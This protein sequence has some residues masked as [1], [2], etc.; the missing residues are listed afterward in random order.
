[1][2]SSGK[3]N[4]PQQAKES[5][6]KSKSRPNS[7]PNADGGDQRAR[8]PTPNF[9][10]QAKKT[11]DD[12]AQDQQLDLFHRIRALA[13]Q[14]IADRGYKETQDDFDATQNEVLAVT[15]ARAQ[16]YLIQRQLPRAQLSRRSRPQPLRAQYAQIEA[17]ASEY[18]EDV[19]SG[20]GN[21]DDT[22]DEIITELEGL[23]MRDWVGR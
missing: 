4:T 9:A 19:R 2:S 5:K 3:T 21:A 11:L 15:L 7:Q 13:K 22:E 20:R 16:H 23:S 14:V 10:D 17:V 6:S 12:M 18:F 8:T 1:M